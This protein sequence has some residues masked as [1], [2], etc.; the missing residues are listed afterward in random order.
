MPLQEK[1]T[2]QKNIKYQDKAV[3]SRVIA[4]NISA[5][6]EEFD[7][8]I[9]DQL[10]RLGFSSNVT[11]VNDELTWAFRLAYTNMTSEEKKALQKKI[12][13]L[14]L[15]LNDSIEKLKAVIQTT[16]SALR[17]KIA[18]ELRAETDQI[19][20]SIKGK[21]DRR[22]NRILE[23]KKNAI[24]RKQREIDKHIDKIKDILNDTL[25]TYSR[26]FTNSLQRTMD[27]K[28]GKREEI[29][30]RILG[31]S[32]IYTKNQPL[33]QIYPSLVNRYFDFEIGSFRPPPHPLPSSP[34]MNK[35]GKNFLSELA[36]EMERKGY[37][38]KVDKKNGAIRVYGS[39]IVIANAL[40][41]LLKDKFKNTAA[42]KR[43]KNTEIAYLD[44]NDIEAIREYNISGY[45]PLMAKDIEAYEKALND[46]ADLILKKALEKHENY[47]VFD[48]KALADKTLMEQARESHK[49]MV[50][51]VDDGL[52]TDNFVIALYQDKLP[53]RLKEFLQEDPEVVDERVEKL[54]FEAIDNGALHR[55]EVTTS[56]EQTIASKKRLQDKYVVAVLPQ[57]IVNLDKVDDSYE[58]YEKLL[59]SI[60]KNAATLSR[61]FMSITEGM[62]TRADVM[63]MLRLIDPQKADVIEDLLKARI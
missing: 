26:T 34:K 57:S 2:K 11:D 28:T 58:Y 1:K 61:S 22:I 15:I 62:E 12:L 17:L 18:S 63:R 42:Y 8:N 38:T 39:Q 7:I 35:E 49:K 40:K 46:F 43:H 30:K 31:K 36:K 19:V 29:I 25:M 9:Q 27:V 41:Q 24:D 50:K 59:D 21:Y 55:T 23:S 45:L 4:K 37:K 14:G 5:M 33:G 51:A 32:R 60:H 10:A 52:R 16:D 53:R 47:V 13:Q 48:F 20:Q 6:E 54:L 44:K 56:I 3:A